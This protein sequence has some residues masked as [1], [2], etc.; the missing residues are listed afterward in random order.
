M[1]LQVNQPIV[2]LSWD[3]LKIAYHVGN[4]QGSP[5]SVSHALLEFHWKYQ[6][7][8]LTVP[9]TWNLDRYRARRDDELDS[10]MRKNTRFRAAESKQTN[11]QQEFTRQNVLPL[12]EWCESVAQLVEHRP[13]KALVLGSN[14][15]ALTIPSEK[16]TFC[17]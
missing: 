11:C 15:S 4:V 8:N 10:T 1:Q 9:T 17:R 7:K 16:P 3:G 2:A 5:P 13:F 12:K 6:A 14:P